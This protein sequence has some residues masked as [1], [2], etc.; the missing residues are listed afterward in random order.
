MQ[1]L[2]FSPAAYN[3][4]ETTRTLEIAK[5]CQEHFD[6]LFA[7]YGGEFEHLIAEAGYPI[8]SLEPQLTPEK[9]DNLYKLD[10][11]Q[12]VGYFFSKA[13]VEEQVKNEIVLLEKVQPTAVITGFV[14]SNNI[15][16]RVAGVPLIWLTQSTWNFSTLLEQGIGTHPDMVDFPPL[17]WL[18]EKSLMK[19]TSKLMGIMMLTFRPFNQ[20]AKQYG[21][22]PT[23]QVEKMWEGDYNLLPEPREF[24]PTKLPSSYHFI[25]PLIG[26]LDTPIPDEI[27]NMPHDKPIVYFAMGSSGQPEVIAKIVEGFAGKPYHVIAPV[28]S[29]LAKVE[30]VTIPEN[31]LVTDWLPAH[32]VNPMADISVIH[33]GIGTTMT[34]CLAG[35]PVVG[36]GMMIEQEANVDCLVRL[37]FAVRIRKKHLTPKRLCTAIDQ[38]LADE[39]AKEKAAQFQKITEHWDDPSLITKFFVET[40]LEKVKV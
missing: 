31:V 11:G 19:I 38:L 8:R 1:T 14:F 17:N 24:C 22:P 39:E 3:L 27:L 5:A 23:K 30:N 2:L 9:I 29:H 37:G 40:F 20:V 7:S 15:S 6:I 26:R 35:K 34:A 18:P 33:G 28:K 10:Q 32:K 36:V 16:C 12:A 13:E 21:L 4:A 25:G